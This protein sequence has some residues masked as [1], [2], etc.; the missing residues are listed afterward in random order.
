MSKILA[1]ISSPQWGRVREQ[2]LIKC[3]IQLMVTMV[4]V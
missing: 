1:P 3:R 4:T 2:I